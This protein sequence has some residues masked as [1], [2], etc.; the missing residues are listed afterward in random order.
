M[1]RPANA[2]HDHKG[3]QIGD[4]RGQQA[5]D[6]VDRYIWMVKVVRKSNLTHVLIFC[7]SCSQNNITLLVYFVML[8]IIQMIPYDT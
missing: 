3:Q 8:C 6:E 1:Q 2:K 4:S 7:G 5:N